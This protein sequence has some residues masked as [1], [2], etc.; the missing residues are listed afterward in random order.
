MRLR[1]KQRRDIQ[2]TSTFDLETQEWDQPVL[3]GMFILASR[4]YRETRDIEELAH[5]LLHIPGAHWAH[6]GGRFDFLAILD[7]WR[8]WGVKCTAR[9]AGG[10][11]ICVTY[12]GGMLCDSA[13]LW[14][15]TLAEITTGQANAKIECPLPCVC[16]EN[17]GGYCSIRRDMSS[18]YYAL[19]GE[20]LRHDCVSLA[21]AL[22]MLREAAE[23]NDLDLGLTIGS[24]A[25][26]N[27]QRMLGFERDVHSL[28]EHVFR[29]MAYFG[30]RTEAFRL[31]ELGPGWDYDIIGMYS[32]LLA[33]LD[34]SVGNPEHLFGRY[35]QAAFLAGKSGIYQVDITVPESY[36]PPLPIRG[37]ERLAYPHGRFSGSYVYAELLNAVEKYGVRINAFKESRV[38]TERRKIFGEWCAKITE[39]RMKAGKKTPLG[40]FWKRYQ[41]SVYGK[42]CA[43]PEHLHLKINPDVISEGDEPI[44]DGIYVRRTSR[45]DECSHIVWGSEVTG[46]G[47]I[48]LLDKCHEGTGPEGV[49]YIDTDGA[50]TDDRRP[51][52]VKD[53][54]G[55]WEEKAKRNLLVIAPKV[56]AEEEEICQLADGQGVV[57]KVSSRAKG[58]RIPRTE[59]PVIGK[60][61][62]V[63]GGVKGARSIGSREK[64]FERND[65]TRTV[66]ERTGDRI[67]IG[68]GRT[69]PP[70]IDEVKL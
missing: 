55:A 23:S 5:W 4:D 34:F 6:N 46:N 60:T 65:M 27:A 59:V 49:R 18:E 62:P 20:Y 42:L 2:V 56:Y 41:N 44:A 70:R 35:S 15:E 22:C 12:P 9:F 33:N 48:M 53:E 3:C 1:L 43:R 51:I 7:V 63:R 28:A 16:A 11:I 45:I 66:A 25:F 47:R 29:R 52:G 31:G 69:R 32:S 13:A 14:P 30:G 57:I 24:S 21:D 61:Y 39:M 38:F 36:M 50:K 26:R 67:A 54:P 40:L 10:R 17:C 37:A 19:L 58:I 64:F 8:R 68:N